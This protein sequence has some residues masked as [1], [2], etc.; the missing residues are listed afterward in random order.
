M[1]IDPRKI[2]VFKQIPETKSEIKEL[3]KADL[4]KF[5]VM[6]KNF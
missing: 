6:L 1:A 3:P 5:Y 4:P 2:K